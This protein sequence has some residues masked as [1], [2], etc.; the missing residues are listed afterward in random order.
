MPPLWLTELGELIRVA[1]EQRRWSKRFLAKQIGVSP[2]MIGHYEAGEHMP[3]FEIVVNLAAIL[4]TEFVIRGYKITAS[5]SHPTKA[6]AQSQGEQSSG[7]LRL[8]L[9]QDYIVSATL[10][11]RPVEGAIHIGG[12]AKAPKKASNF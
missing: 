8:D 10:V 5:E 12:L 9:D 3:S 11:L 2:T 6:S 7:Q 4:K 1:R